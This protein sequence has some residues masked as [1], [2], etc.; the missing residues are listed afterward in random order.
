MTDADWEILDAADGI[1][2]GTATYMDNMSAGSRRS[3][4]TTAAGAL[5]AHGV[6]RSRP[7]SPT[8]APRAATSSTR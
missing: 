2:L 5:L 6:T 1:V 4:S 7:A 8:P 3:P